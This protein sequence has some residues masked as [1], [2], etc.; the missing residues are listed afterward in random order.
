[1]ELI[2]YRNKIAYTVLFDECDQYIISNINWSLSGKNKR[3]YVQSIANKKAG[4]SIVKMHRL[5]LSIE[6]KRVLVDHKNRN[7]LDNRRE[8]LRVCNYS[9]NGKNKLSLLGSSSKFLGVS[10]NKRAKKWVV[11]IRKEGKNTYLGL[12]NNEIEAA[13][14]YDFA[15]K[16]VHG[17]FASLN[18]KNEQTGL[19]SK[20]E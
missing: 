2:L 8:N 20:M 4:S 1:M 14:V 7:T 10:W 11:N 12:Y 17:E 6:D 5:L 16:I 19:L 15:A 18:F 9:E 3:M 13:E